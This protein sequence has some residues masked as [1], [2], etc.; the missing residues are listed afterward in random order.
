MMYLKRLSDENR[1]FFSKAIALYEAAFPEEERR[2]KEEQIRVLEKEAYH[3][4]FIMND[5][6]FLGVMLYWET[7]T[8][9]F[10]EHFVT[11]PEV[12]GKGHGANALEL[13]K[14]K[15]KTIILEIEPPEDEITK[16]RYEFY[17]RN[18]FFMNEYHHIQAKYHLGDE[19]FIL[20]IMS[21]PNKISQQEYRQF[22]E[23][24]TR[25]IGILAEKNNEVVVR[26]YQV[27]DDLDQ[28]AKLIY[29]T[30]PYIYPYWFDSMEDGIKVL[31]EM[32]AL[33]TIYNGRNV[34]VAVTEEGFV[35]GVVVS[36]NSP[37]YEEEKEIIR[38]FELAGITRDARTHKIFL[39]YYDKMAEE[40]RGHYIANIAVDPLFQKRGIAATLI[41]YVVRNK[42]FCHLEC[43]QENVGAW[44]LYQRLGFKIAEEYPGVFDVPCYKMIRKV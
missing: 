36:V 22:Y 14:S 39:D 1:H 18:G 38:A 7:E 9:V 31:R 6:E 4:D 23:Y 32:I 27:G 12:R 17:L 21:Y 10:L 16:R 24:M 26:P 11:L 5:D 44:R 37:A 34:T 43:V 41:E 33:P 42:S 19:D 29:L 25:E 20:K 8:F 13:L 35:A 40:K 28:I 2:G 30:D 3:F 15:N